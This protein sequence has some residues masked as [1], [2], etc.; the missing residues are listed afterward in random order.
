MLMCLVFAVEMEPPL[1]TELLWMSMMKDSASSVLDTVVTRGY[2][3]MLA[4]MLKKEPEL[5][6]D[7]VVY[8]GVR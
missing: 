4:G 5:V 1:G 3:T 8:T 7:D 2:A 6:S